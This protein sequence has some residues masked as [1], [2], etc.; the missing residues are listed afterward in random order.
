VTT[1][2]T[3]ARAGRA[4]PAAAWL[5]L[6]ALG[7]RVWD[8]NNPVLGLDEQWY[9]L[10]GDRM[11]RGAVPYI[12]LWDRKPVGLF[13]LYA[14]FRLLPGDGV[15]AYQVVATLAAGATAAVVRRAALVAGAGP[16]G[17]GAAGLLYLA[18]LSVLGGQG[19]QAPVFY[20]LPMTVA[21]LLTLGLFV[22]RNLPDARAV[23]RSGVLA[24]A[25]A[26]VAIQIKTSAAFEGAFFGVA[27]LWAL[28]RAG[29]GH[30]GVARSAALLALVGLAPTLAAAAAYA[31]MGV[32]ALDAFWFAN[33]VSILLRQP[34]PPLVVAGKLVGDLALLLPL[35]VPAGVAL[36][37]RRT[38]RPG[39]TG[40]RSAAALWLA[41][42]VAGFV[43]IGTFH[44]HY[45]LPLLAPLAVVAAPAL[46]EAAAA[47][48]CL[49]VA[50]LLL[51]AD[52][53]R[54]PD[55]AASERRL[56]QVVRARSAPGRCPWIA[57]G[58]PIA[59][60]LADACIP[61]PYA[62]PNTL[63]HRTER[64]ATGIDEAAEAHRIL[65]AR[66]PMLAVAIRR[67]MPWNPATLAALR[68]AIARDYRLLYRERRRRSV[69]LVF[70]PR[71]R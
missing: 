23:L 5:M 63:M 43:A 48:A 33:F 13:L 22:G 61:T 14:G 19:G 30:A 18:G 59:Y 42:A 10:V 35:L 9:L 6:A 27:H 52:A 45:A 44:D 65:A 17:A 31:M 16:L 69:L 64:G 7:L 54:R 39:G 20:N 4:L 66:P 53:L 32:R 29:L 8:W 55:D 38:R 1:A 57:S 50:G 40:V 68:A 28:R 51:A 49:G 60:L 36:W 47:L 24:C 2:G 62:F 3:A 70:V 56:A 58:N 34:Y 67:R 25:L 12:D 41:A 15:L 26:G 21:A 11:W 37:R 71:A 46:D